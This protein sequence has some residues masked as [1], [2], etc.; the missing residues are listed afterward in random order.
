MFSYLLPLNINQLERDHYI[1]YIGSHIYAQLIKFSIFYLV[2][3]RKKVLRLFFSIQTSTSAGK[4]G[5]TVI[6]V[7][8]TR[9]GAIRVTA[10]VGL[11]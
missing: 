8:Q 1:I 6:K 10:I 3:T 9:E 4:G 2:Y 5:M 7:A 11:H